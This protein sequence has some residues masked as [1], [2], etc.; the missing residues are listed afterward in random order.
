[1][2]YLL[3]NLA[4]ADLMVAMFFAPM[5]VFIHTFTH[6]DGVTGDMICTFLTGGAFGWVGGV[7][8]SFTLAAIAIERYY[9]VIYPHGNKGKL[10]KNKLKVCPIKGFELLLV[11]PAMK[12]KKKT[13][14]DKAFSVAAASL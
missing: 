12:M 6:P 3:V 2:N 7:S 9:A 13:L 4:V 8:S 1:M 5:H 14:S 11:R 10:T